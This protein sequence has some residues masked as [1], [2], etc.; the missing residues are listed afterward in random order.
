MRFSNLTVETT[1]PWNAENSEKKQVCRCKMLQDKA[2]H[3]LFHWKINLDTHSA[4]ETILRGQSKTA[5][6]GDHGR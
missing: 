5:E 1:E 4:L 6:T 2:L 3:I